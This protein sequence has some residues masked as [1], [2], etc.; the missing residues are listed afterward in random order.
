MR[1]AQCGLAR[2]LS[3]CSSPDGLESA[4][5]GSHAA[6][7]RS[8]CSGKAASCQRACGFPIK[9][10][11]LIAAAADRGSRQEEQGD[12]QCVQSAS[13]GTQGARVLWIASPPKP[14]ERRAPARRTC[15]TPW[16]TGRDSKNPK[17]PSAQL[18]L[19]LKHVDYRQQF[20]RVASARVFSAK[21]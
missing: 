4:A 11:L 14:V 8:T 12:L 21:E 9:A 1:I 13:R 2:T 17:T 5:T 7:C 20:C 3:A 16:R 6:A 15:L 19:W 18:N 10:S